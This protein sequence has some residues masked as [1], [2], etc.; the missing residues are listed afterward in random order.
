[1]TSKYD[2]T[3]PEVDIKIGAKPSSCCCLCTSVRSYVLLIIFGTLAIINGAVVMPIIYDKM[4][5]VIVYDMMTLTPDS[6]IFPEWVNPTIPL[7][8]KFYFFEI[9]NPDEVFDGAKPVLVEKGPY[10]YTLT[11]RRDNVTN[12][13]NGTVSSIPIYT[14]VFDR[15]RSVGPDT[16]TFLGINLPMTSTAY[17]MKDSPKFVKEMMSSVL[18]ELDSGMFIRL[19]VDELLFGYDEPLFEL[20]NKFFP[21][22]GMSDQFG[23]LLGYNGTDINGLFTVYDGVDD[24][25]KINRL[26]TWKG[27]PNLTW[28]Y[29]PEANMMNGTDGMMYHPFVKTH[30]TLLLFHPDFCRTM[31]YEYDGDESWRGIPLK[32][33]YLPPYAYENG[34]TYPPNA[35]FCS[36]ELENCA[37]KG[38]QRMDACR[39]G[40]PMGMSNPHFLYGDPWLEEQVIGL[41]PSE[42]DH[43]NYFL[44]EPLMGMPYVMNQRLQINQY[45]KQVDGIK[46]MGNVRTMYLPALWFLQE[47]EVN[48]EVVENYEMGFVLTALISD[49]VAYT[50]IVIGVLMVAPAMIALTMTLYRRRT[51]KQQDFSTDK[52]SLVQVSYKQNEMDPVFYANGVVINDKENTKDANSM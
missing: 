34:T 26:E 29:T 22:P 18:D 43:K 21:I 6:P 8:S 51:S 12:H 19:T 40:S 10:T 47:V 1:M 30:E 15:E 38:I 20:I 45:M 50:S 14:Y 11:V 13:D 27:Q 25:S 2:G 17:M 52:G 28:W 44:L 4:I 31:P 46:Q 41:K 24:I 16:D 37:P 3:E 33:Y 32:R 35:G 48:D 7:T 39:F 9:T 5:E 42:E 36:E 49:I 23:F